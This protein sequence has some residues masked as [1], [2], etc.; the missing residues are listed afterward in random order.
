MPSID[1]SKDTIQ[2]LVSVIIITRNRPQM[3]ADCLAHL[4]RQEFTHF[5]IVVIDSSSNDK[6]AQLMQAWPLATYV[7]IRDAKNNM[8]QARNTGISYAQGDVVAFIDDDCMVSQEWLACLVSAYDGPEIGGTGGS[9]IDKN[10]PY[11]PAES[12]VGVVLP[13]GMTI[14]NFTPSMTAPIDVEWLP[15]GNMSFTRSALIATGG[16]DSRFTGDNSYEEVDHAL[17]VRKL[18]YRLRFVPAA[19]VTHLSAPRSPDTPPRDFES[20]KRRFYL[21]RN[22]TYFYLKNIGL[23]GEFLYYFVFQRL[24]GLTVYAMRRPSLMSWGRCIAT[25]IGYPAGCLAWLQY[26]VSGLARLKRG[27]KRFNER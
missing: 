10:I 18:G 14:F 21:T 27:Q 4:L 7:R 16:F 20:P 23:S 3:L 8:P 9:L 11:D 2:P 25:L 13:N 15:G 19:K 24:R 12:R 5:E 1:I 22:G 6:T 26:R 17:R